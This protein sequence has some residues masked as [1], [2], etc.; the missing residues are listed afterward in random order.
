[1]AEVLDHPRTLKRLKHTQGRGAA[2]PCVCRLALEQLALEQL[3]LV[4]WSAG[5]PHQAGDQ[6]CRRPLA[7]PRLPL[8]L[9]P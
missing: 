7:N 2:S 5:P 8:P 4:L 3:A 6:P 1:M 9:A